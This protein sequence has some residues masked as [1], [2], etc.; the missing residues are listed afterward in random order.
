MSLQQWVGANDALCCFCMN[1]PSAGRAKLPDC[2]AHEDKKVSKQLL[3]L[4]V[5]KLRR[6][7]QGTVN[8]S[9]MMTRTCSREGAAR[10]ECRCSAGREQAARQEG[11]VARSSCELST[12]CS[13]GVRFSEPHHRLRPKHVFVLCLKN[14][15]RLTGGYSVTNGMMTPGACALMEVSFNKFRQRAE[16]LGVVALQCAFPQ[17]RHDGIAVRHAQYPTASGRVRGWRHYGVPS[18]NY[19][20]AALRCTIIFR[21]KSGRVQEEL[22]MIHYSRAAACLFTRLRTEESSDFKLTASRCA[23]TFRRKTEE[24]KKSS[25]SRRVQH[26]PLP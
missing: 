5:P 18:H 16:V 15:P 9:R 13:G 8:C 20:I 26:D 19:K 6:A 17:L 14:S 2:N 3:K 10:T 1:V 12:N 21:R 11:A 4:C 7:A 23:I 24:F 22:N 25:S